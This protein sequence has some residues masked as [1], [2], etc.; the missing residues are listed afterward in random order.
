MTTKKE[1]LEY[2]N[3]L[4]NI[5]VVNIQAAVPYLTYKFPELSESEAQAIISEWL[6]SKLLTESKG[7]NCGL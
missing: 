7:N 5:G 6:S 1:H 2:L 3:E 4:A